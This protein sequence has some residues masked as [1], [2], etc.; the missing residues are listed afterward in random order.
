MTTQ[1]IVIVTIPSGASGLSAAV[2]L[3]PR[4]PL[5]IDIPA[6]WIAASLTF[7]GSS[8]GLAY[9]DV[10]DEYGAEYVVVPVAGKRA[11]IPPMDALRLGPYMKIRSGTA[12][13]PVNQTAQRL[14]IV[15]ARTLAGPF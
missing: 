8:D 3:S 15:T 10:Y 5:T 9:L 7:Q 11:T 4:F 2:A 13:A 1:K 14:L 12:A 6:G